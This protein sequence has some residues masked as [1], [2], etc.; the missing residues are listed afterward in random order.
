ME[1]RTEKDITPE[2]AKHLRE[3]SGMTQREFWEEVGS[4]QGSG[5]WFEHNKRKSGIPRPIRTLLF[6]RHVIGIPLSVNDPDHAAMLAKAAADVARK[7]DAM[8]AE[9][10]AKEAQ[11]RAKELAKQARRAAV[12]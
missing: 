3:A 9:A 12:A 4:N 7:Y 6:L 8:R 1:I 11:R 5:H 10:E 2:V